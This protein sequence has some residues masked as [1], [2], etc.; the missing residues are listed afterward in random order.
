MLS[1][2][3]VSLYNFIKKG[4]FLLKVFSLDYSLQSRLRIQKAR[5]MA[6]EMLQRLVTCDVNREFRELSAEKA[7]GTY[8]RAK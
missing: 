2:A 5:L 8:Q 7:E 3:W 4:S 1:E 6:E